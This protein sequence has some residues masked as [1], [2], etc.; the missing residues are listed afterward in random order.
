MVHILV[1]VMSR[2]LRSSYLPKDYLF[3]KVYPDLPH[4]WHSMSSQT[5]WSPIPSWVHGCAGFVITAYA[6]IS[7]LHPEG[8]S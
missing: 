4:G 3:H 8:G 2:S 5:L 6:P 1:L 7:D